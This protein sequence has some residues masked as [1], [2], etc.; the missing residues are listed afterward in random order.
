M[1]YS[2]DMHVTVD[3]E[4][5]IRSV[6][7]ESVILDLKTER[8]LGLDE[9]GTRMWHA[10]VDAPTLES[11]YLSLLAEYDLEPD[12]LKQELQGFLDKLVANGLIHLTAGSVGGRMPAE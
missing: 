4:V 3:P 1:P 12:H 8:Y 6:G 9:V 7:E 5:M 2:F 10:V 11:A